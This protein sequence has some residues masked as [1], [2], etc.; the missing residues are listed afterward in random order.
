MTATLDAHLRDIPWASIPQTFQ[1][2]IKVVRKLGIR[3]IW[4]NSLCIIQNDADDWTRESALMYDVYSN[5]YLTLSAASAPDSRFGLFRET[6]T[7]EL[8]G[9]TREDH[10]YLVLVRVKMKHPKHWNLKK[11]RQIS[12]FLAGAGYS[13][14]RFSLLGLFISGMRS[15]YGNAKS[16][17]TV[18]A[19]L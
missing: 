1:D 7:V 6:E 3:Y 9:R 16:G 15:S 14:S 8:S 4:I 10:P 17:W 13:R 5:A 12:L 2:A 19:A 11:T 18:S